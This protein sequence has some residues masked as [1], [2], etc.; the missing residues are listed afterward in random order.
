MPKLV[1]DKAYLPF[2]KGLITE[3]SPL[4]YPEGATIDE[5]N[6]IISRQGIRERRMGLQVDSDSSWVQPVASYG[7]CTEPTG[8]CTLNTCEEQTGNCTLSTCYEA[9]DFTAA[10]LSWDTD[11]W[12]FDGAIYGSVVAYLKPVG[13]WITGQ[14]PTT[15]EIDVDV[16]G[17]WASGNWFI[18]YWKSNNGQQFYYVVPFPTLY[19]SPGPF[20]IVFDLTDITYLTGTLDTMVRFGFSSFGQDSIGIARSYK[21]KAVRLTPTPPNYT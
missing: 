18:W 13:S 8:N 7:T 16:Y 9:D 2:T 10:Q 3:V 20:T 1:S 11:G 21:I 15:V 17:T 12:Y 4:A 19:K 5:D 14:L 6:L